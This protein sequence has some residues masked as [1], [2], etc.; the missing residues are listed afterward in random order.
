MNGSKNLL[1]LVI[2]VLALLPWGILFALVNSE[3]GA[4]FLGSDLDE[5]A[6]RT[7]E[8]A[9][10]A[11]LIEN[12]ENEIEDLR[13]ALEEKSGDGEA[14]AEMEELRDSLNE[15]RDE[16]LRALTEIDRLRTEYNSALSE[17]V[18]MKTERMAAEALPEPEPTPEPETEEVTEV[19]EEP[20]PVAPPDTG[21][22]ILPP[23]N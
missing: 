23:A 22:W 8:S 11:A 21:G 12:M 20:E 16:K 18:R 2:L 6:I 19:I 10:F 14:S 9:R 4:R 1:L 5:A 15:E 17:V 7:D 3:A 13:S